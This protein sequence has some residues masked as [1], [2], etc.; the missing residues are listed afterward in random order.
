MVVLPFF[1][2]YIVTSLISSYA[3]LHSEHTLKKSTVRQSQCIASYVSCKIFCFC[4]IEIKEEKERSCISRKKQYSLYPIILGIYPCAYFVS[5]LIYTSTQ[6][7]KR[8]PSQASPLMRSGLICTSP[9]LIFLY[10]RIHFGRP[11]CSYWRSDLLYY[12]FFE[13]SWYDIHIG[14]KS[15]LTRSYVSA[16]F[17][18]LHVINYTS[19]VEERKRRE[20]NI[21]LL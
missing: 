16:S 6:K 10:F 13:V 15:S 9:P 4:D 5:T 12:L 11:L 3:I 17:Q 21:A 18:L 19:C 7:E 20:N 1:Q 8:Q 2:P 14:L